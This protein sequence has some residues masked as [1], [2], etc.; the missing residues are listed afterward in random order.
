M[1]P[2]ITTKQGAVQ[3]TLSQDGKALIFQGRALCPAPGGKP[4][5]LPAPRS[6]SPGKARGTAPNSPPGAPSAT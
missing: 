6:T 4:P 1:K 2:I 5:A 3:G